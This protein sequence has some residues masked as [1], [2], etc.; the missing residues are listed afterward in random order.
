MLIQFVIFFQSELFDPTKVLEFAGH[1]HESGDYA[2]AL[3]EYS[4]YRF[5]SDTVET[6][7]QTKIIDCMIRLKRFDDALIRAR[8]TGD[9]AYWQGIVLYHAARF[10]SASAFLVRSNADHEPQSRKF[11]GLSYAGQFDFKKMS[12]Y[13]EYS[14][15]PPKLKKPWL[16]G[17]LSII[18]GAGHAYADRLGDGFFSFLTVALLGVVSYHYYQTDEDLKFG[19]AVSATALFYAGNIYGG[20]NAARNYNYYR[21]SEYRD[22]ILD[23]YNEFDY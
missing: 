14:R 11:I 10:D 23:V 15:P 13:L 16:G 12:D 9:P 17:L 1:L 20:V 4:R 2:A 7:V 6:D 21:N 19:I 22:N 5:L 18:P 8:V 3:Q